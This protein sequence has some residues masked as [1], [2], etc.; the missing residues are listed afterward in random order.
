MNVSS[1]QGRAMIMHRRPSTPKRNLG[2]GHRFRRPTSPSSGHSRVHHTS[3]AIVVVSAFNPVVAQANAGRGWRC[4]ITTLIDFSV[5]FHA[6]AQTVLDPQ[7]APATANSGVLPSPAPDAE[8]TFSAKKQQ[9]CRFAT[10]FNLQVDSIDTVPSA[11][12]PLTVM[13]CS[14][15]RI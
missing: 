3:S 8:T 13:L 5:A 12:L 9:L 4:I 7:A 10:F 2:A 11:M 14:Q 1:E 6:E 15:L